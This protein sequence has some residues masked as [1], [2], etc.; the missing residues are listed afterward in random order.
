MPPQELQVQKADTAEADTAV[1]E[2]PPYI[3]EE[4]T[5]HCDDWEDDP[6]DLCGPEPLM[7]GRSRC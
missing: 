3:E 6:E 2:Q 4:L 5:E 7:Y 1:Q